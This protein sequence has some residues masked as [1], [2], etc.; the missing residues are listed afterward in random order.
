MWLCQYLK[1][2][3]FGI[4]NVLVLHS[5][6]PHMCTHMWWVWWQRLVWVEWVCARLQTCYSDAQVCSLTC[7]LYCI[8]NS[9]TNPPI[10]ECLLPVHSIGYLLKLRTPN[11][12]TLCVSL[13]LCRGRWWTRREDSDKC[14]QVRCDWLCQP[15][16]QNALLAGQ[17]WAVLV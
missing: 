11:L 4:Y 1:R 5:S 6:G 16:N 7:D 9:K 10:P 17:G 15:V 2:Q 12:S 13:T 14:S 3:I 8:A